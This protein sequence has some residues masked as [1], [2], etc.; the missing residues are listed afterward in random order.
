MNRKIS[1]CVFYFYLKYLKGTRNR[2]SRKKSKLLSCHM[3]I[4]VNISETL[5]IINNNLCVVNIY[6]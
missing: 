3:W 4:E 6:H 5:L 2:F 1:E